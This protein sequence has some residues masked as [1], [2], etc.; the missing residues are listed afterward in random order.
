MF[1][2]IQRAASLISGECEIMC[3]LI[4]AFPSRSIVCAH[5]KPHFAV[6]LIVIKAASNTLSGSCVFLRCD[7]MLLSSASRL[8]VHAQSWGSLQRVRDSHFLP[9]LF[10]TKHPIGIGFGLLLQMT[11]KPSQFL[12]SFSIRFSFG[13]MS[14]FESAPDKAINLIN[15]L[16]HMS[17]SYLCGRPANKTT[18][19]ETVS[20][21]SVRRAGFALAI[22]SGLVVTVQILVLAR[23]P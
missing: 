3:A 23:Q 21:V 15:L 17:H 13:Y 10:R 4:P 8:S 5:S 22:Q 14:E 1:R 16:C 12:K 7:Y 11:Q 9:A 20:F 19:L 6:R 2:T 18:T